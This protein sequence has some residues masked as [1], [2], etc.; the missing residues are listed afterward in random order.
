MT[1]GSSNDDNDVAASFMMDTVVLP[2]VRFFVVGCVVVM[3]WVR[4]EA[5]E[6]S[7]SIRCHSLSSSHVVTSRVRLRR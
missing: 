2:Q 1:L 7:A 6:E 3:R 4:D 5:G